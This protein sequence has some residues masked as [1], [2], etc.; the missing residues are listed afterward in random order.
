MLDRLHVGVAVLDSTKSVDRLLVVPVVGV[1]EDVA[2]L[3]SARQMVLEPKRVELVVVP[4][5]IVQLSVK[6]FKRQFLPCKVA[7]G[8]VGLAVVEVAELVVVE[9]ALVAADGTPV[10]LLLVLLAALPNLSNLA[11]SRPSLSFARKSDRCI[12]PKSIIKSLA[13]IFLPG[14]EVKFASDQSKTLIPLQDSSSTRKS[15]HTRSVNRSKFLFV[16][17]QPHQTF[18]VAGTLENIAVNWPRVIPKIERLKFKVKELLPKI[19]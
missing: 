16:V 17:L 12:Y 9:V 4:E 5:T 10:D 13:R 3:V 14:D 7:V 19:T 1:V 18:V 6:L 2:G 15:H 8:V 11:R